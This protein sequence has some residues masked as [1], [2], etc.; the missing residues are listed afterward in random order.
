MG[1]KVKQSPAKSEPGG[2]TSSSN[3]LRAALTRS[4]ATKRKGGAS[5]NG[6]FSTEI[7]PLSLHLFL[8]FHEE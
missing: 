4:A 3:L 2:N 6:E 7:N 8:R 1:R 5:G